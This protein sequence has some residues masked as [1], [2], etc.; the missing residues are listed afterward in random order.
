MDDLA[1]SLAS[2]IRHDGD[3]GV[4]DKLTDLADLRKWV[5]DNRDLLARQHIA[6]RP[7]DLSQDALSQIRQLRQ[8][9]RALFARAV[10]PEPPSRADAHRIMPISRALD[11][12]NT[13]AARQPLAPRLIWTKNP[14]ITVESPDLAPAD[15]LAAGVARATIELLA[16][17]H[18][19]DLRACQAPHCVLYFIKEHPRQQWC[20]PSCGTR[21]RVA[22]HYHRH[23]ET[24]G[25]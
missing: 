22:R 24:A 3:G 14:A 11:T 20:T 10:R 18:R 12:V 4:A 5:S 16:G 23:H 9:I 2:T 13:A 25:R 7:G 17:P 8:A 15:R 1:L 19:G 21:A 6:L